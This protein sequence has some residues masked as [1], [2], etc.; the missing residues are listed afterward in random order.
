MKK[1]KLITF[2]LL[3]VAVFSAC[4]K[5]KDDDINPAESSL[6]NVEVGLNNNEIGVIG[7]DFHFNAEILAGEK[8]ENVQIKI[9]PR[10]GESYDKSWKME[11]TWDEYRGVKNATV[12]KHFNI[13]EDAA[14]GKYDFVIIVNDQNGTTLEEKREIKI[15]T[16]ANLPVNPEIMF[17]SVGADKRLIYDQIN[18]GYLDPETGTFGN[19]TGYINKGDSLVPSM[20][21]NG[22]KGDGVMYVV[23]INKKHNHRPETIGAIDFTKVIIA[24]IY[25]HTNMDKIGSF[26]NYTFRRNYFPKLLIGAV[27]DNSVPAPRMIDHLKAWETGNYYVG[28]IYYNSTYNMTVF[29]Y[30]DLKINY[31]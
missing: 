13:P 6:T 15:Y 16:A 4:K 1:I 8:I 30:I 27:S 2:V 11:I 14:E 20:T 22:I 12:H 5:D 28:M 21:V 7:K 26:T 19:T 23:L 9:L 25:E 17:F 18:G 24:D 10:S 3:L 29:K 31:N